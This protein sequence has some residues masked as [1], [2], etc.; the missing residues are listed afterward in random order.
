[1]NHAIN[2]MQGGTP[3]RVR[4]DVA[5]HNMLAVRRELRIAGGGNPLVT[6]TIKRRGQRLSNE[7]AGPC[8]QDAARGAAYL[9][10]TVRLT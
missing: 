9:D 4:S 5:D 7:A 2:A 10:H 8:N 3:V 1:M 6:G